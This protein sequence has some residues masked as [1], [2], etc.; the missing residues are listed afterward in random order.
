MG[1]KAVLYA[2]ICVYLS[3]MF[4]VGVF[5]WY[6]HRNTEASVVSHYLA[7]RSLG[8][9]VRPPRPLPGELISE[10]GACNSPNGCAT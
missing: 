3:M 7:D 2:V 6:K 10:N 8:P 4:A 1:D 9:V 5:F